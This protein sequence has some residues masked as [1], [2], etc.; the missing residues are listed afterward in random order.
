MD[1]LPVHIRW[2]IRRDMGEVLDIESK[3]FEF[4]WS[5][6]DF[7]RCLRQRNAIGMVAEHSEK[8]CGYFIYELHKN[9]IE[10]LNVAVAPELRRRRIGEQI[11]NKLLSKLSEQRRNR[12][13]VV[14]RETNLP[15]QLFFRQQG[16]KAMEVLRGFYQDTP[17]DAYY[18]VKSIIP[19]V[20]NR[21]QKFMPQHGGF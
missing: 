3:T 18:M 2:M 1:R 14:V 20:T 17:E 16:F 5:E 21:I 6:Q 19:S 7:T 8:I 12:I 11:I 13:N 4:P 9:W 10:I 15:A